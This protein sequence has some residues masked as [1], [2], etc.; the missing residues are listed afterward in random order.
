MIIRY[1]IIFDAT[2]SD[3]AYGKKKESGYDKGS[4]DPEFSSFEVVKHNMGIGGIYQFFIQC[5]GEFR[6]APVT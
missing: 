3:S 5:Q 4:H 1:C 6:H 2:I